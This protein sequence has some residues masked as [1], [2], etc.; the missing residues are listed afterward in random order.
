MLSKPTLGLRDAGQG[1]TTI[2]FGPV[3]TAKE[4]GVV[5]T[6]GPLRSPGLA[7]E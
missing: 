7:K 6:W 3:S 5:K 2:D 1:T 4:F